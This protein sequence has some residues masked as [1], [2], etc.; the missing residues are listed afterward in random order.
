MEFHLYLPQM[1]M[2]PDVLV[3]RAQ[4]AEA[5]GFLGIAGMDHLAPPGA[6]SQPMLSA[7]PTNAWLAAHTSN[8]VV[9]SLVLCDP[10]RH[11]ALLAQ[12]AVTLDHMSKGRFELG[13]GWGSVSRELEA[14][15]VTHEPGRER[16]RRLAETLEIVKALWTGQPIDYDGEFFQLSG[17]QMAPT[18]LTGIPIVIGG[19]GPK[20][21][22]LVAT[23]ADWWNVH[24]GILD[25]LE[26]MMSRR[27]SARASVEHMI[28]FVPSEDRREEVAGL[29]AKRFGT[30]GVVVGDSNELT[31]FFGDLGDKGVE[32]VYAWF[33][34]FA[35]PDTLA[36]FGETVIPALA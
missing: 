12:E 3:Q 1:R 34:D 10:F 24:I 32:R 36:A 17:A 18:P 22:E 9:S 27:G 19:A 28:A 25:R 15:G 5:N 7:M 26:E 4:A 8:L 33:T 35:D 6:E 14:Y 13:I 11:P 31:D 29:A 16:V 20:T 21:M 30:M 23:H 2:E